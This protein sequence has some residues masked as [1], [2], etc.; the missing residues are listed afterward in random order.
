MKKRVVFFGFIGAALVVSSFASLVYN[1]PSVDAI[2]TDST[3]INVSV[4]KDLC[5]NIPGVQLTVPVGMVV[6][7]SHQCY[8]PAPPPVDVCANIIGTQ[9]VVPA[10]YYRDSSGN[11][12]PQPVAPAEIDVC[13]NIDG[14]QIVVPD[15]YIN[16]EDGN[17]VKPPV[18]QC[19]NIEGVQATIPDGMTRDEDGAC[20]TPLVPITPVSPT[21]PGN[22]TPTLPITVTENR[23][24]DLAIPKNVPQTIAPVVAPIVEAVPEPIKQVVRSLPPVVAQSFP[25]FVFAALG[26]LALFMWIQAANEARTA[27]RFIVLLKRERSIAEQKDNFIALASHY[28]RTP[29]TVMTNGLDAILAL[30]EVPP[31]I[32]APLRMPLQELG[33][34]IARILE[35]V[36]GNLAESDINQ[37]SEAPD[38]ASFLKSAHFWGP[39]IASVGITAFANFLLGVVGNVEIGTFNMIAQIVVFVLAGFF[40]YSA[41]RNHHTHVR[42]REKQQ[43]LLTHE[44]TIDETRNTF[45]VRSTNTLQQGLGRLAAQRHLLDTAPSARFFDDGFNRFSTILGK[46]MLLS[47]IQSGAQVQMAPLNLRETVDAAVARRAPEAEAK[48]ITLTND[49]PLT[50]VN[51]NNELF[52]FVLDSLLDN[53]I[54]FTDVGGTI[55]IGATPSKHRMSIN[56]TDTGIGIPSE[57][58]SQLFKPFSRTE[59]AIDFNYEG[60]GFSLFLDKIIMD[61]LGGN[62]SVESQQ[63]AGSTFSITSDLYAGTE[64]QAVTLEQPQPVATAQPAI[65]I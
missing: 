62:I 43:E 63:K 7:A 48:Q 56:I 16:D 46:F 61:Y 52:L 65:A 2:D 57:K 11:C 21:T 10:G 38:H 19:L 35:E 44:H 27:S 58:Q 41:L 26:A 50:M 51:Q 60:L 18:D 20:G 15:G 49:T 23:Q 45:L 8:T 42:N 9:T 33:D 64:P 17:C 47:Q 5:W 32:V 6:N 39:V 12:Y 59:S 14:L 53:A 31:D 4:K 13:P 30:R 24:V 36:E 3:T 28:L 40:L 37:P 22:E 34:S 29:L 1:T 54:K 25:Y 55:S